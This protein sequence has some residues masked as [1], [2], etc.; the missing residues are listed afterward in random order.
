MNL[1]NNL[2]EL[3]TSPLEG[4]QPQKPLTQELSP[5]AHASEV[6]YLKRDPSIETKT[7]TS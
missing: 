7:Q 4:L 5:R 2:V 6:K 3:S 1:M